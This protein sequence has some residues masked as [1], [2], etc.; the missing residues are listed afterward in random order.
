MYFERKLERIPIGG[1]EFPIIIDMYVLEEIQQKY[2]SLN[3]FENKLKGIKEILGEDSSK[4]KIVRTEKDIGVLNFVLPLMV[5]EGCEIEGNKLQMTDKEIVRNLG[6]SHVELQKI[7]CNEF[8]RCF[9]MQKKESPS[10]R[11]EGNN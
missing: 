9:E 8:N 2:G 4:P 5:K 10:K 3:F 11:T 7:V 6:I 1:Q